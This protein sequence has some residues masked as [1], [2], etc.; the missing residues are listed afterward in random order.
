MKTLEAL[1]KELGVKAADL[2]PVVETLRKKY[3]YTVGHAMWAIG[4]ALWKGFTLRAWR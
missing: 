2:L 4:N 3:R 1:E